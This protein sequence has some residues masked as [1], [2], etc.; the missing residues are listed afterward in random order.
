MA[1]AVPQTA[2][3]KAAPSWSRLL[4]THGPGYLDWLARKNVLVVKFDLLARALSQLLE[5]IQTP[6]E[7]RDIWKATPAVLHRCNEQGTYEM[8]GAPL[9][10]AWLHLLERYARTWVALE[11]LVKHG[12]L[13]IARFGVRTL[14]VGTGPG[15]S[16]FAI[17]DFYHSLMEFGAEEGIEALKQPPSIHLR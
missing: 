6:E 8:S 4:R 14:D 7:A 12:Y 16:A 5:G 2:S 9:A 17:N 11:Q 1:I 13:P 10:Y 3:P 15:P